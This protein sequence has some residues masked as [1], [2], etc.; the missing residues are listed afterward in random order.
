VSR[1]YGQ[2]YL[3][4]HERWWANFVA[5]RQETHSKPAIAKAQN[6]FGPEGIRLLSASLGDALISAA[7]AV[8]AALL[9]PLWNAWGLLG[10]STVWYVV[11]VWA[12]CALTA[13][14][15]V[16]CAKEGKRWRSGRPYQR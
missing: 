7:T 9:F 3:L 2:H 4:P 8:V 10:P 13:V 5:H 1:E 6:N 12:C 16:Q 15:V 11:V 14:R